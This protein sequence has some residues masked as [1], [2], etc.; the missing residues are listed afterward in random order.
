MNITNII[1]LTIGAAILG[2]II[3]FVVV[4]LMSRK[5]T[6][7]NNIDKS[8]YKN[9]IESLKQALSEKEKAYSE[10][11][12]K[13]KTVKNGGNVTITSDEEDRLK[14]E[15]SKAKEKIKKLEN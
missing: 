3:V 8:S 6:Q 9:E 7:Q 10:L 5:N 14:D 13:L 2:G 15:I 1:L 12:E 4:K 11:K